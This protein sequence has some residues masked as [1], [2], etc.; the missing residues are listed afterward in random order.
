MSIMASE[1]NDLR[2]RLMEAGDLASVIAMAAVVHP[3]FHEDGSVYLERTRLYG[4]GCFVLE[5]ASGDLHGYAVT[6][7]WQFCTLPALDSLLGSLPKQPSTYYLHDIAL[8]PDARGSGAAPRIVAIVAD[9]AM[10]EG[11]ATMSLVSVNNSSGFWE[12]QGFEIRNLPE[13]E[14]KLR[15]YSDDACF[16]VRQ[17]R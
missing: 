5:A 16:M 7:P 4:K 1:H 6:H 11:L 15:T 10:L 3:G 9:Q 13:L 2:W 14:A 12:K 8:M 17:L